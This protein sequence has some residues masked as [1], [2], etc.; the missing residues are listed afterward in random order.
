MPLQRCSLKAVAHGHG[1][2]GSAVSV[3]EPNKK[4]GFVAEMRK[5][6]MKLHTKEQAPKEG[7]QESKRPMQQFS[8]TKE[9]YLQ[10]LA[11]SKAVYDTL[12]RIMEDAKDPQYERFQNTGL[13]RSAPL[14]K[15][16]AWM[17]ETY[18][19]KPKELS[20]DGPGLTYAK[21]LED[22][23]VSNPPAFIC[24]YYN[25]YFAHTAGGR[26][27]GNKVAGM[28]L[29]GAELEFYKYDGDLTELLESVRGNLNDIAEGWSEEEKDVCLTET[30]DS[31]K[32]SGGI[33]STI[34][35]G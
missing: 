13:E 35:S 16:I 2:G 1:H 26:M 6:A 5:V 27:I 29:D 17:E 33:M 24:H 34:M 9:G 31:F 25:T 14:A 32:Y 19:I 28:C 8:P 11:E 18:G 22:L 12:E 7:E 15:D 21:L 20:E 4:T 23:A 10:F 3:E 30:M